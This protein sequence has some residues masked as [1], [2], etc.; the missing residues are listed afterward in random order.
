MLFGILTT[1]DRT[2]TDL[3][4]RGS[5]ATRSVPLRVASCTSDSP[6][7][8]ASAQPGVLELG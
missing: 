5:T 8:W 4:G 1:S 6:V 7:Q 3:T 2:G